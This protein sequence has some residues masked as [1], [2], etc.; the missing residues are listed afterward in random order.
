MANRAEKSL[1]DKRV[2]PMTR[3]SLWCRSLLAAL[4]ILDFAIFSDL[5]LR[6]AAGRSILPARLRR[7]AFPPKNA[8][9]LAAIE[10]QLKS[11][12]SKVGPSVI[13]VGPEAAS[14]VIVSA[15]GL[16][17]TQG[18]CAP[19]PTV[20]TCLA[21]GT[22]EVADVLGRDDVFDL[23]LLKLRKARSISPC[24]TC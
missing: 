10:K 24:R 5:L 23:C 12:A 15:D 2:F 11:V 14:G 21:D 19:E 4:L 18:H 16:V 1:S 20:K 8:A 17:L 22:E 7:P 6:A 13:A 9:D 3:L